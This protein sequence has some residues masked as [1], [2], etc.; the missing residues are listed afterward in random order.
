MI[1]T[2]SGS[3]RFEAEFI[4]AQRELSRAGIQFF[5][6]AVLPQ[7]REPGENWTDGSYDKVIADLLYFDRILRSDA[8]VVLGDGY[9]GQSTA[10]EILWAGIQGKPVFRHKPLQ[11]WSVT[12]AQL[13]TI[14]ELDLCESKRIITQAKAFFKPDLT[15]HPAPFGFDPEQDIA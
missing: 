6:L 12:A 14:G 3:T 8:L 7:H 10:R 2:L 15:G 11:S 5:S 1:V 13:K 4:K 9:I